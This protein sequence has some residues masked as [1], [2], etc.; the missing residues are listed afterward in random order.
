MSNGIRVSDSSKEHVVALST[1]KGISIN[2]AADFLIGIAVTR[3]A[4][5][6]RYAEKAKALAGGAPEKGRLKK[7]EASRDKPAKGEKS[8]K[9]GKSAKVEKAAKSSKAVKSMKAEKIEK[10]AKIKKVGKV[11][12]VGKLAKGEKGSKGE[13][14]VPQFELVE[15][16]PEELFLN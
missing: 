8:A 13:K 2:E 7:A 1:E 4:A 5:L 12:K 15:S 14:D 11:G 16:Q 3:R 9:A 6:S 10:S